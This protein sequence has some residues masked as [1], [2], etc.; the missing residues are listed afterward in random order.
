MSFDYRLSV[1]S[2]TF[3]KTLPINNE[4]ETHSV[5]VGYIVWIFGFL[6]RHRFYFGN[7]ITGTIWFFTGGLLLIGWLGICPCR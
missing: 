5:T 7:R 4:Q 2:K 1:K 6:A 3:E